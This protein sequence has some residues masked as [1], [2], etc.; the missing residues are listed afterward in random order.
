MA[1]A[2]HV[3]LLMSLSETVI[4]MS[5]L[6]EPDTVTNL[7]QMLIQDYKEDWEVTPFLFL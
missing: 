4:K 6:V 7:C 5:I 2:H 3:P 1:T